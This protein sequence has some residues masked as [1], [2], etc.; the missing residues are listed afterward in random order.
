MTQTKKCSKC[1]ETK[2]LAN[3]SKDSKAP[4]NLNRWCRVCHKASMRFR[5]YKLTA[6]RFEELLKAQD[7][8]CAICLRLFEQDERTDVDHDH[9]C[10]PGEISCGCCV[11]GITH[12]A[13]NR[14][15]G[16]LGESE[17]SL[18]NALRYLRRHK[19]RCDSL[20]S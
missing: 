20:V 13:C 14:A 17:D 18:E 2:T 11:R 8:R 3:F 5:R 10:C 12:T 6:D 7:S 4:D 1:G 19:G 15:L 16:L 9:S